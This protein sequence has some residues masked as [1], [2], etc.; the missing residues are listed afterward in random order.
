M[1][2]TYPS[3]EPLIARVLEDGEA[4][5]CTFVCPL[6]DMTYEGTGALKTGRT[7]EDVS[8]V[9]RSLLDSVRQSLGFLLRRAL[10]TPRSARA[11]AG[12]AAMTHSGKH[13]PFSRSERQAAVVLAF[14]TLSS[15]FVW[16]PKGKRWIAASGA[17][18]LLTRFA[19][20]L[21]IASVQDVDDRSVLS[22]MLVEVARADG[23]VTPTE[24]AVLGDLIPGD[25]TS[26]DTAMEQP[27]LSD[28][29]LNTVSKGACRD[30]MLML[31]WALALAD[32]DMDADETGQLLRF[33]KGLRVP[34]SRALELRTIARLHLI[35]H[36]FGRAFPGGKLKQ[37]RY[38][39]TLALAQR[40]G[41]T[42]EETAQAETDF[43]T[44]SGIE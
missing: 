24:W 12:D 15:R 32:E 17:S 18:E 39:E 34:E 7:L 27:D 2:I 23:K 44:R 28:D 19:R 9:D 42:P 3:V 30:T 11:E 5:V 22:R 16:D 20:Q 4:L 1:E 43:K 14:K 13:S 36:S 25:I 41:L 10:E 26:V 38:D 8:T 21:E 31:T 33:A 6:T 40:I 35:E 29:E 37:K